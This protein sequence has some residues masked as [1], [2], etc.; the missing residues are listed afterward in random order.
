MRL[1]TERQLA[2]K[3]AHKMV[4]ELMTLTR[5]SEEECQ[6]ILLG[7]LKRE[8][9]EQAPIIEEHESQFIANMFH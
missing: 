3:L 5:L 4:T 1:S 9:V 2:A 8:P 6:S 7:Q